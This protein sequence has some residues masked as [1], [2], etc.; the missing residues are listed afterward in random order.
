VVEHYGNSSGATIPIAIYLNLLDRVKSG[1]CRVCLAG[2]GVGL[3][4]STMLM[5][6]GGLAYCDLID[7]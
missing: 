1:R 6:L 2:F 3:T 5:D 4:W 7:Y